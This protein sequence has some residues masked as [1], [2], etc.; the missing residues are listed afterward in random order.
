MSCNEIFPLQFLIYAE[1]KGD[2]KKIKKTYD[3]DKCHERKE[4]VA[5]RTAEKADS[6]QRQY[7]Q[8]GIDDTIP[9]HFPF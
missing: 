1:G 7:P 8:Y 6:D 3:G 9:F 2:E 5:H 4:T